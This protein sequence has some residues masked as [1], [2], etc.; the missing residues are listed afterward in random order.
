MAILIDVLQKTIYIKSI[1][2]ASD[3][4]STITDNMVSYVRMFIYEHNPLKLLDKL[5]K[6]IMGIRVMILPCYLGSY[7]QQGTS[8]SHV[9]QTYLQ[10]TSMIKGF[11]LTIVL[12]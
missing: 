9:F 8:R 6:Y 5:D 3:T 4:N 1:G 10:A 12:K 2:I 11:M 7:T